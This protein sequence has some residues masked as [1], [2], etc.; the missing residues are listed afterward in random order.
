MKSVIL[1]LSFT[2]FLGLSACSQN[3]YKTTESG[4]KYR[5]IRGEGKSANPQ[6]TDIVTVKMD[7]FIND[8]L[9]FS[10]Q[11]LGKPMQFPLSPSSFKGDFFEGLKMMSVGDS[12]SFLC[13]AD[14]VFLRLFR[15]KHMPEFVKPGAIMRFEI[16]L[17]NIEKQADYEAKKMAEAKALAEEGRMKL[18]KYIADKGINVSPLESGL[19]YIETQKGTGEQPKRGEKIK[20]HY[21][22]TLLDGTQFDAS[23]DRNQPFEFVLGMG[24]VIRGWDE[25]LAMM[26]VG[27]KATLLIP[28]Q[29]GYGERGS[30][31]IPPFSA[32]VFEVELIEIIK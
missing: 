14:S 13:P 27:G 20:V 19:Y 17:D 23:Y 32:L 10:G 4:L 7:Y 21:R 28:Y 6:E 25:G 11:K 12:A 16:A 1:L 24:Q 5:F 9:L 3:G 30:G 31:P 29:L 8:S 2:A 22:G 15:V 26:N 18:E